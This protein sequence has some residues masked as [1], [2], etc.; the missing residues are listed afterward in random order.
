A[1]RDVAERI[2]ELGINFASYIRPPGVDRATSPLPL[3]QS[4]LLKN[5]VFSAL[6]TLKLAIPFA[7]G[8]LEDVDIRV[9]AFEKC[10]LLRCVS[11]REETHRVEFVLPYQNLTTVHA[12]GGR[13]DYIINK[14]EN[15][16]DVYLNFF[17]ISLSREQPP[18]IPL[19]STMTWQAAA[20]RTLKRVRFRSFLFDIH[21]ATGNNTFRS[22]HAHALRILELDAAPCLTLFTILTMIPDIALCGLHELIV[23]CV[24][25]SPADLDGPDVQSFMHLMARMPALRTLKISGRFGHYVLYALAETNGLV[26]ELAVLTVNPELLQKDCAKVVC[27]ARERRDSLMSVEVMVSTS[28]TYRGQEERFL[29]DISGPAAAMFWEEL[30]ALVPVNVL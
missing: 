29:T 26:P 10:P 27:F 17:P 16:R 28:Y 24:L 22:L 12:N 3:L 7:H 18:P 11:L 5:H 8:R 19:H 30:V 20:L 2:G 23:G 4:E 9:D 1:L 14:L 21:A 25:E 15:P 13:L 6:H